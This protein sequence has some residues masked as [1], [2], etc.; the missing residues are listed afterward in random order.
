[1]EKVNNFFKYAASKKW[2]CSLLVY[3]GK[4]MAIINPVDSVKIFEGE[5]DLSDDIISDINNAIGECKK[6]MVK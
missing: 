3:D 5:V 2:D 4:V 6:E 1:M